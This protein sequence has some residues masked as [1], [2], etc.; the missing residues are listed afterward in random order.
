MK[1][2][3][4]LF[5]SL[6]I[7]ASLVACGGT[8]EGAPK[9]ETVVENEIVRVELRDPVIT[10]DHISYS[11]DVENLSD[12][13]IILPTGRTIA[14]GEKEGVSAECSPGDGE[15]TNVVFIRNTDNYSLCEIEYE[16]SISDKPAFTDFKVLRNE[17]FEL[18]S[19]LSEDAI[20]IEQIGDSV[21]NNYAKDECGDFYRTLL[22]VRITNNTDKQL[23]VWAGYS[24]IVLQPGEVVEKELEAMDEVP[25][26][27]M[28]ACTV[29][30][31][32]PF[33]LDVSFVAFEDGT[34]PYMQEQTHTTFTVT[35]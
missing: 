18:N 8:K 28:F 34:D 12:Q 7:M 1:K 13:D 35:H 16:V 24:E 30:K 32:L 2:I 25:G 27:Y 6:F 19:G 33:D 17:V 23:M 31:E 29:A 21:V 4:S 3:I 11:Y 20:T 15:Y 10:G 22:T 14:P 9:V 26:D 5:L